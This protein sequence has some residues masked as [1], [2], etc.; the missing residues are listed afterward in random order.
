MLG[1]CDVLHEY[2]MLQSLEV[3]QALL[4]AESVQTLV[5]HA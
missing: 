2:V 4:I 1:P 3:M 5:P